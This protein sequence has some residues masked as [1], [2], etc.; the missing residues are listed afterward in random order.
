MNANLLFVSQRYICSPGYSVK[1]QSHIFHEIVFYGEGCSGKC[2]IG[3]K[4][5]EF[6]PFNIAVNRSKM[7]HSEIHYGHGWIRYLCFTSDDFDIESGLYYNMNNI[8]HIYNE[9]MHELVNKLPDYET[10]IYHKLNE[11]YLCIKRLCYSVPAETDPLISIK[12]YISENYAQNI[13]IAELSATTGYSPS[14][15]R[16]LFTNRF[17]IS[18]KDYLI[19]KRCQ[20][21]IEL[22]KFTSSSCADI[23]LQC[24]FYDSS[25]LTK[26]L[27][28]KYSA[29]PLDIRNQTSN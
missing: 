14:H 22:L 24:G 16:L 25:Q 9:L 26:I 6:H 8:E 4:E 12:K 28:S 23:A 3:D 10:M 7:P 19:K 20:R 27:K 15:F 2:T 11:L 17:G 29:T 18:P 21:A 1:I 13:N 5:Y